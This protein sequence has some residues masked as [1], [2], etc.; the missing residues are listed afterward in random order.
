VRCA[1][2]A[3]PD[4]GLSSH[5][6]DADYLVAGLCPVTADTIRAG[7][8]LKGVLKHGVGLD[9]IDIDACTEAGIPVTN[10]PGANANAVAEL[11]IGMMIA[12]S[13]SLIPSHGEVLNG[14]WNRIA[15]VEIAGRTLGIVGLGAVGKCLAQ[16]A[17]VLGMKIVATDLYPDYTFIAEHAITLASLPDL[18]GM[19]DFVSLHVVGGHANSA[20]I[21][22]S[23]LK[24]MKPGAAL[25]NLARGEVV[26]LDATA[27]ALE[28]GSLSGAAFD[29]YPSEPPDLS[30]PI[31]S[32]PRTI[33][34]PHVGAETTDSIERVSLMNIQD[35]ETLIS[36]GL[37]DRCVN[38]TVSLTDQKQLG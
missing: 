15:G 31:F 33:F 7:K 9:G 21:G 17:M 19:S 3:L 37:P 22:P 26:D 18:L 1:D 32:A 23:E 30:H 20:L 13:R 34:S 28:T 11:A 8:N 24:L 16:K 2:P 38:R 29:T 36:G 4:G 5:I 6:A 10:T 14:G 12:M 27:A 25:L 35:I